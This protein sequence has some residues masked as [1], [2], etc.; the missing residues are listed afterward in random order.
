MKKIII[1]F[2]AVLAVMAA[3]KKIAGDGDVCGC[4]YLAEPS[5]VF[6][7]RSSNGT[8]LLNTANAGH[9]TTPDIKLWTKAANGSA[10]N[11]AF[12]IRPPFSYPAA[13]THAKYDYYQVHSFEIG[14]KA[15]SPG[16]EFYLQTGNSKID[17]LNFEIDRTM[18]KLTKVILNKTVISRDPVL[19][20][21]ADVY[22][23]TR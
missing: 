19:P 18:K 22:V 11:I 3:C 13:N 10:V 6:S 2:F 15:Q 20:A 23:L 16:Q 14:A 1:S 21:G 5:F 9:F 17:T 8:D 12:S 7:V 4:T